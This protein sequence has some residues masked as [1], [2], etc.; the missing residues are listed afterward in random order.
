MVTMPAKPYL[1]I[2]AAL[3]RRCG[4]R[5]GDHVLLAA[6]PAE[7]ELTAYSFAVVDQA[8]R[9]HTPLCGGDGRQA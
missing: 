7:D 3:R 5:P 2:P 1:V 9:A 6:S 4:L 8:L